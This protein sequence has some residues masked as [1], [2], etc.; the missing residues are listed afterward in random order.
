MDDN[1]LVITIVNTIGPTSMP[2]NE[3]ACY[4]AMH[5]PGERHRIIALGPVDDRLIE[6][7][8]VKQPHADIGAVDCHGNIRRLSRNITHELACASRDHY[9]TVIHIHQPRTGLAFHLMRK[10]QQWRAPVLYTI[11]STKYDLH[12]RV[13]AMMNFTLADHI[14]FVSAASCR[15]F[16]RWLSNRRRD[17]IT[18]IA[19][20]VDL[21]RVITWSATSDARTAA[22]AKQDR[23]GTLSLINVGRLVQAKNQVFLLELLAHL[24]DGVTLTIVGDGRLRARLAKTAAALGV[25]DRVRFTGLIQREQVY[26]LVREADL[27]LSS[28]HWEGLPVAV[29]EAMT[30]QRPVILSDIPSHR[31]IAAQGTSVKLVPFSPDAWVEE[32]RQYAGLSPAERDAWGCKNRQLVETAFSLQRMHD[33]Y[34]RLY[35]DLIRKAG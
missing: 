32:I 26:R 24:G 11:H 1:I 25:A 3:F 23:N 27:F 16:P 21:E 2:F 5:F 33:E 13:M 10:F 18:T 17:R 9:S 22:E 29:L 31:E 8:K 14:S 6:Q 7:L 35:A 12:N 20:G 15:M 30:L 19:N 4:R 34:S 28:S